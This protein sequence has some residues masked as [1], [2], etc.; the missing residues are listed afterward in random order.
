MLTSS[1]CEVGVHLGWAR[2][3][4]F[5]GLVQPEVSGRAFIGSHAHHLLVIGIVNERARDGTVFHA[6]AILKVQRHSVLIATEAVFERYA[7]C[8]LVR[9]GLA[10]SGDRISV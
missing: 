1:G 6:F 10:L 5:F 3:H 8:A 7:G 2:S 4:A 9:A